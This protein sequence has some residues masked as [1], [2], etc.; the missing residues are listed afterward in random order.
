[1]SAS[2]Q[3]P[4][5]RHHYIP[6]FYLSRWTDKHHKLI[7]FSKPHGNIVKTRY[8]STKQTAWEDKLYELEGLSAEFAQTAEERFFQPVDTRAAEALA[9]MEAGKINLSARDRVA[10]SQFLLTLALRTPEHVRATVAR[11]HQLMENVT[12][13]SEKR[14]RKQRNPSDPKTMLSA[15]LEPVNKARAQRKA[16]ESLME[17]SGSDKLGNALISMQWGSRDLPFYVPALFTSDRP[18]QWFGALGTDDCHILLPIGPKRLS[19]QQVRRGCLLLYRTS[20]TQTLP[21]S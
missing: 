1:M 8:V 21:T 15:V 17:V 11:M 2:V 18:L 7:E 13:A 16:L 19:G 20:I 3:N 6:Q 10:W 5:R 12:P 9:S 4:P 14:W